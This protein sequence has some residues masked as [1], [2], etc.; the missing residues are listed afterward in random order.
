MKDGKK[1]NWWQILNS[2]IL[3]LAGFN[4]HFDKSLFRVFIFAVAVWGL[5]AATHYTD[6]QSVYINCPENTSP[7]GTGG[8]CENPYYNFP[9]CMQLI[10]DNYICEMEYLP[11]GFTYGSPPDFFTRNYS[12]FI[13][14][15][16]LAIVGLNHY[17]YNRKAKGADNV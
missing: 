2:N 17:L 7:F 9:Q 11:A 15:S 1:L 3:E 5:I 12:A 13:L 16:L 10:N 6:W 8:L 14:F 4:Y